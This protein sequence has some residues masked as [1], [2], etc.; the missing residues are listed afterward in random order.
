M[1]QYIMSVSRFAHCIKV[2]YRDRIGGFATPYEIERKMQ[3]WLDKFCNAMP[4]ASADLRGRYPLR[5]AR[6]TVR[7]TPDRPGAYRCVVHLRP[8]F[9]LDELVSDFR[10]ETQLGG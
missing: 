8:G 1:L 4:A 9:Q 10:L 5:E 6:V 7:D 2:M 3:T